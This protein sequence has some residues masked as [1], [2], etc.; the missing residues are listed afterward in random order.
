MSPSRKDWLIAI[1][2]WSFPAS[3]MPALVTISYVFYLNS[4]TPLDVNW[5]YG[6]LA[7]FGAAFFQASGN[8]ISDYYD[9]LY[10][11]DRKESFGSSRMLVDGVFKPKTIL[12]YG[13]VFLVIG[14]LLGLF[15][16]FKTSIH[17]LWIGAIGVLGTYFYYKMKYRALGD[18]NIFI[19]Y[20]LC[21]A[22]GTYLVMTNML[23]WKILLI[24]SSLGFLIVNILH[25]NNTRDIRDDGKANIK[26]QAM[27]LGIKGSIKQYI[28]LGIGA[29]LIITLTVILGILHPL[30]LLVWLSFPLLINNIK[31]VR[32]ASIEK[33]EL[34][35]DLDGKSAQLVMIFSMLLAISNFIA[36][37][38]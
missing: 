4:V 12:N 2:P 29:Y 11:V 23:S 16:L 6:V 17:L 13:L 25:A 5:L 31:E 8:L 32:L 18:L 24:G 21:I 20:G 3:T 22:L 28:V 9:Y 19:I 10:T 33:P 35:K 34:I 7:F 38:I 1:R 37:I 36:G 15:L 26:T 30:C 14:C 27:L